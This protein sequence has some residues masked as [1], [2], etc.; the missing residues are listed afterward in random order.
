[1]PL[2]TSP[3][4]MRLCDLPDYYTHFVDHIS[5]FGNYKNLYAK[6]VQKTSS[7]SEHISS[8]QQQINVEKQRNDPRQKL[9]NFF[10]F[11]NLFLK[12]VGCAMCDGVWSVFV[13]LRKMCTLDS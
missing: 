7:N 8:T 1:M 11:Q 2:G 13:I 12:V 6:Y 9:I 5:N 4:S 10:F 3:I